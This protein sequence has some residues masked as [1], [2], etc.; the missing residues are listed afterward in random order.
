MGN[1]TRLDKNNLVV[2]W[3]DGHTST[4]DTLWLRDNCTCGG[5]GNRAQGQKRVSMLE[6]PHSP[7]VTNHGWDGNGCLEIDWDDDGHHSTYPATWLREHCYC[8]SCRDA[9]RFRPQLWD[10]NLQGELPEFQLSDFLHDDGG[11]QRVLASIVSRGFCLVHGVPT[12]EKGFEQLLDRIG[13]VKETNYG[14]ICDLK[15]TSEGRLLGDT[16]AP[17]PCLLYTSPSPRDA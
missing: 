7:C 13:Y 14:R 5:C 8:P 4:Y 12:D 3:E 11:C 10:G 16:N 17:I 6:V 1:N 15:V 9:R 2:N